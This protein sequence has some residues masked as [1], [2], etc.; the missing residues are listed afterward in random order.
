MFQKI[1]SRKNAAFCSAKFQQNKTC[2]SQ[3]NIKKIPSRGALKL[4]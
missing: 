2:K 1:K 4:K 3:K